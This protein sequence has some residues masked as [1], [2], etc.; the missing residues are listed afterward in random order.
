VR[1]RLERV[2]GWAATKGLRPVENPA[3]WKAHLENLLPAPSRL[4]NGVERHHESLPYQE[5]GAVMARLRALD[6]T[7]GRGA[8]EFLILTAT[9]SGVV[10]SAEWCEIDPAQRVWAIPAAKM[11]TR[12]EHRVP[13][14]DAAVEVLRKAAELR[15]C[16]YVFPSPNGLPLDGNDMQQRVLKGDL[17]L[18]CASHGFRATFRTWADEQT[19]APHH[20]ME[21]ALAH[22]IASGVERAYRR[23]DLF[24]KRRKLMDQWARYCATSSALK[25][26]GDKVVPM[27]ARNSA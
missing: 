1:G 6:Y 18:T 19:S 3:R 21:Q 11:K 10:R 15:F 22:K 5:I 2:L 17:D 20:V 7:P 14:S 25:T 24:E 23:G 27:F 12:A 9:R 4:R 26:A 8:L 13:L 16:E